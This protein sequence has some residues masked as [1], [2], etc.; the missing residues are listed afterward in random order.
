M[1]RQRD[2]MPASRALDGEG[3]PLP[4]QV[5]ALREVEY[6][7]AKNPNFLQ[8]AIDH[9]QSMVLPRG[10]GRPAKYSETDKQFARW[11]FAELHTDPQKYESTITSVA[12]ILNMPDSAVRDILE[13][14]KRV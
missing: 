6:F 8:Y 12:K 11:L 4:P 14:R 1:A 9:L 5:R 3:N 13:D 10:K 7:A 2:T